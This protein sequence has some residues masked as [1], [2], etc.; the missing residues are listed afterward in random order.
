MKITWYQF[1]G[2]KY[3]VFSPVF[4]TLYK[5]CKLAE[6]VAEE[7]MKRLTDKELKRPSDIGL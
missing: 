5:S 6:G 4:D 7:I 2:T 3:V 1:P